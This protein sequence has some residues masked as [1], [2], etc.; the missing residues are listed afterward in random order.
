VLAASFPN[1]ELERLGT[2]AK[3]LVAIIAAISAVDRKL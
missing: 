1:A 3:S 2:T